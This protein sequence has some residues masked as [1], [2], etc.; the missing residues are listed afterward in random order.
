MLRLLSQQPGSYKPQRVSIPTRNILIPP[1]GELHCIAEVSLFAR[2]LSL[3]IDLYCF[4]VDPACDLSLVRIVRSHGAHIRQL[5]LPDRDGSSLG[6][7]TIQ[8]S[9][10]MGEKRSPHVVEVGKA[11]FIPFF[12]KNLFKFFVNRIGSALSRR[13]EKKD[14][15]TW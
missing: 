9:M 12:T 5:V 3:P 10:I 1:S 11:I 14:P 15:L 4:P 13:F 2:S 8:L 7:Q 6:I